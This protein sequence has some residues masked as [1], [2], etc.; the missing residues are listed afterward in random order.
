MQI[1]DLPAIIMI[2]LVLTGI[3]ELLIAQDSLYYIDVDYKLI[4]ADIDGSNKQFIN[5]FTRHISRTN[6]RVYFGG[7]FSVFCIDSKGAVPA[8]IQGPSIITDFVWVNES[9][10]VYG[11]TDGLHLVQNGTEK[12]LVENQYQTD[13]Y[14]TQK[15]LSQ[16]IE[17][18]YSLDFTDM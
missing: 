11:D 12:W 9:T 8:E 2:M 5:D 17:D 3:S 15:L 1:T 6:N 10:Y 18:I 13:S 4:R 7:D 16:K 14:R